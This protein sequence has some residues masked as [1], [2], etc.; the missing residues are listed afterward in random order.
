MLKPKAMVLGHDRYLN[1]SLLR[2]G[3][4]LTGVFSPVDLAN[5]NKE[6]RAHY[7][8]LLN[9]RDYGALDSLC[10]VAAHLRA[11]GPI[12]VFGA[13]ELRLYATAFLAEQLGVKGAFERALLTRDKRLMKEAL[14]GRVTAARFA[15]L[16]DPSTP[17]EMQAA[18]EALGWPL[19]LKPVSGM[20]SKQTY[21]LA[22]PQDLAKIGS[23]GT[24]EIVLNDHRM[25]EQRVDG[26][27]FHVDAF[28]QDGRA[29]YFQVFRYNVAPLRFFFDDQEPLFYTMSQSEQSHRRLYARARAL[30]AKVNK[31]LGLRQGMT[32]MEFFQR[33]DG[34]LVFSEIASRIGGG[35]V[36]SALRHLYGRDPY[37][38]YAEAGRG[39][40]LAPLRPKRGQAVCAAWVQ[41]CRTGRVL[42]MS[43]AEEIQRRPGVLEAWT[44]VHPGM[45]VKKDSGQD[46]F[47][48]LL[49][50]AEDELA[51]EARLKDLQPHI[52]MRLGGRFSPQG[53]IL[54]ACE[55]WKRWRGG[56]LTWTMVRGRIWDL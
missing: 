55:A 53:L 13:S 17:A 26:Q 12:Q 42:E 3:Y 18:A 35:P 24:S 19:V 47:Y 8:R 50:G 54:Q 34:H 39:K 2:A 29:I 11:E 6:G 43:S 56:R 36:R 46:A 14:K 51:V 21:L 4:Q 45:W 9:V 40:R 23:A 16:P 31:R 27:E 25:L 7:S 38:L 10:A 48:E 22:S 5:L 52:H 41:R 32:H 20:G 28:W 30:Q 49:V 44:P 15:S 37:D 1:Q 33:E